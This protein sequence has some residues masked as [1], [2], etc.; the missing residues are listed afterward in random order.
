MAEGLLLINEIL[1]NILKYIELIF[2]QFFY[3]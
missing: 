2:E 3:I 1:K